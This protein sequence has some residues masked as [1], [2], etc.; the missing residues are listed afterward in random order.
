MHQD[1]YQILIDKLDQFIR[2]YYVN[3]LIRGALYTLATVVFLFV[4][5]N[6]LEYFYYFNTSVRK[7]MFYGFLG[8]FLGSLFYWDILPLIHYFRLGK[9]ISH[10]QAATIIGSHFKEVKD[11]LLNILQLNR[12]SYHLEHKDLILASINQKSSEL[13]PVPF[14]SAIDLSKNSKYLKYALPPLGI[15]AGILFLAPSLIKDST[16]RIIENDKVFEKKAPFEFVLEND[17]LSIPQGADFPIKVTL[18]GNLLPA[19]VFVDM[20]NFQYKLKKIKN[21]QYEYTFNNVQR[22]TQ[23]RLLGGGFYSQPYELE[24]I[25]RPS[26]ADLGIYLDYPDYIGRS[27]ENLQNIGDLN[28]PQ[29]TK[30]HW[31]IKAEN[32][33]SLLFYFKNDKKSIGVPQGADGVFSFHKNLVKDDLYSVLIGNG[34]L[35]TLDSIQY[36]IA[37]VPDAYPTIGVEKFD[38]STSAKVQYFVGNVGDDYGVR[39]VSFNYRIED[40]KGSFSEHKSSLIKAVNAREGK[41]EFVFDADLYP[42][43]SGEKISFYFEVND[44]D[45][46]NGSKKTKSSIMT[47]SRMSEKE[48]EQVVEKNEE[49]IKKDLDK[50]LEEAKKI[51]EKLKALRE[52][53]LQE[54]EVDWKTQKEMEKLLEQQKQ[55]E[56]KIKNAQEKFQENQKNENDLN[57][58]SEDQQQKKENL[59]QIF[60]QLENDKT[61][62]LLEK[63][64]ELMEKLQKDDAIKELENSKAESEKQEMQ[65]ERLLELYKKLE[66]ESEYRDAAEKLEQLGEKQEKLADETQLKKDENSKLE[67]QQKEINKQLDQLDKTLQD[68]EKKNEELDQPLPLDKDNK[69]DM[70]DMKNDAEDGQKEIKENKNDKA[71]KSQR[72]A[73]K[74][75]K[76]KAKKMKESMDGAE[77]EQAEEDARALRQ[78]LENLMAMSFDQ[79]SLIKKISTSEVQINTPAYVKLIQHQNK[80]KDDFK[81]IDDSLSALANRVFQIQAMVTEKVGEINKHLVTGIQDLE[82]R[83]IAQASDHQQR[84]MKNVNDLALMLEESLSNMNNPSNS[85]KPGSKACKKPGSG[86]GKG[87]G[88]GGKVPMDKITKGQQKLS[89]EMKKMA[90]ERKKGKSPGQGK[91][92]Q[93]KEGQGKEGEKMSGG[94]GGSAKEFAEMAAKQAA[95]RKALQD[96]QKEK[97]EQGKG[98][99]ELQSIIDQMDKTEYDLVNKRLNAETLKRQQEILT[100]L[101]DAERADREQ[102]FDEQRKSEEA[103]NIPKTLPPALQEYIKKKNAETESVRYINPSLKP[104]YKRLAESYSDKIQ[105]KI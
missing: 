48:V 44:N 3:Q 39:N 18:K 78:I 8:T 40:A 57:K 80:L 98:S 86:E 31:R 7:L 69:E 101:L 50:V 99:K 29:G 56:E 66:V 105:R 102:E 24:V 15:L 27:D 47:F 1:N 25:K 14:K 103:K 75:M 11:K 17:Q 16:Q 93:G 64:K 60:K 33:E 67:E 81:L 10:D 36:N 100:K 76:A 9:V 55:V 54:K 21:D 42:L 37:V 97:Q 46:V 68:L 19:E 72:S 34:K 92:G 5:I 79:E 49:S 63:I 58:Q 90:E 26:I 61:K 35:K 96:F 30:A 73:S 89:E 23:F 85:S 28:V 22:N 51:Q 91:E 6:V 41:F 65:V 53:L 94:E 4:L 88:K 43:Q 74:K 20:D 13:Q 77:Q 71:S 104:F 95:L 87:K 83:S 12:Q 45:Q 52:K 2:K 84:I 38:D 32:T 59:E 62:D 82:D 70:Q